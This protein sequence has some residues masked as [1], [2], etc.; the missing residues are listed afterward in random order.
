MEIDNNE[1]WRNIDSRGIL[2]LLETFIEWD[3]RCV[4]LG[5]FVNHSFNLFRGDVNNLSRV[6]EC[7]AD[8]KQ[9]LR[10]WTR[11]LHD[12]E[13]LRELMSCEDVSDLALLIVSME[14]LGENVEHLKG[15]LGEKELMG[16]QGECERL[17]EE[18]ERRGGAVKRDNGMFNGWL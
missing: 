16:L 15:L 5:E 1:L 2:N 8:M 14:R 18:A 12:T 7:M 13:V 4:G 3:E 11:H 17:R 9:S 6:A 10:N